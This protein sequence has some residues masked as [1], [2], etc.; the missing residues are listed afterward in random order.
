MVMMAKSADDVPLKPV[1]LGQLA[2][3]YCLEEEL[4]GPIYC[5]PAYHCNWS[6]SGSTATVVKKYD[7]SN[8]VTVSLF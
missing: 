3:D 5:R 2:D 8:M 7:F 1:R 6:L 4:D